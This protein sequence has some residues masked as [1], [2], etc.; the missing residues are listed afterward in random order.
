MPIV[1]SEL[2]F[3][4]VQ[5]ELYIG[6]FM[7]LNNSLFGVAPESLEAININFAGRES[8]FVVNS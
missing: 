8:S 7:E 4:Q 3:F 6:D 5:R 1:I 2:H